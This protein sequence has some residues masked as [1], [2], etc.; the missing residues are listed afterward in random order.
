MRAKKKK[1]IKKMREAS[2]LSCIRAKRQLNLELPEKKKRPLRNK[3]IKKTPKNNPV[4]LLNSSQGP[5]K[6]EGKETRGAKSIT[7]LETNSVLQ[8]KR[9]SSDIKD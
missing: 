6:K 4:N 1:K 2:A 7:V 8:K 3:S 5:R 9:G